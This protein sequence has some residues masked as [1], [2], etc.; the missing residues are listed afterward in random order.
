VKTT[1]IKITVA[2]VLVVAVVIVGASLFLNKD[3]KQIGVWLTTPDQ[4]KLLSKEEELSFS[5]KEHSVETTIQVDETITYQQMEGFGASLTDSSA[6]LID[7]KLNSEQREKLMNALF[8]HQ[9][10]IGISYLRVPMGSSD[11]ALQNYTYNDLPD[12]ETD[13]DLEQFTIEYDKNYIIPT[14]KEAHKINPDLKIMGSPWSPPAWMKT[15]GSLIGGKLKDDA[16]DPYAQYFARFVKAYEAEGLL[17]DAITVQNE[18]HHEPTGYPG[19]RM[20]PDEQANFIKNHLGP[21]FK[22][23][24]INTKIIAWDHNWDEYY[25]PIEVLNDPEANKY[26]SGSAFHGYAGD[27][28]NQQ[29]VHDEHPDKDIYFTESSGGEWASNFG[30]NLKWDVQTLI[31][32]ATKNWAK[33]V[34]KWNLALDESFGPINGGCADCRGFVTI[35]Q[36]TGD[37]DYNVEYYSFGHSSKF[38]KSGAYRI[39]SNGIGN[40][41]ILHVAFMNPDQSKVLVALNTYQEDQTFT[42][43]MDTQSFTYTLPAGAVATFVWE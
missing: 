8:D 15:S 42:V 18:P 34:L 7:K 24:K 31:I 29:Y 33:T 12:R 22:N 30:D 17:I 41:S 21:V 28:I 38:V 20:E 23:E 27:V 32:G 39:E 37:V 25:Y 14:L 36:E 16:Y 26:I 19:M 10:G 43:Q 3:T 11:F 35:N 40:G 1:Y 4:S 13:P 5:N 6:W 9:E 2:I